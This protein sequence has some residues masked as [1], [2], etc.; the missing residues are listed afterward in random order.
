M[1]MMRRHLR[2]ETFLDS[3][4]D[5]NKSCIS[6]LPSSRDNFIQDFGAQERDATEFERRQKIE[7]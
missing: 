3:L 7:S 5:E 1:Q 6:I 4:V 2:R